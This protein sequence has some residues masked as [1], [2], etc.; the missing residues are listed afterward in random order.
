[1]AFIYGTMQKSWA[2][3]II[4]KNIVL[5]VF[6]NLSSVFVRQYKMFCKNISLVFSL[7]Y[8]LKHFHFF[9][10]FKTCTELYIKFVFI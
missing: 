9:I 1:M 4:N 7:L 3:K 6:N 2:P 8:F 10:V 5:Y